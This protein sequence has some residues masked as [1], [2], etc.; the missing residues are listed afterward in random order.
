M[1]DFAC[2]QN[3]MSD[4]STELS[5][6]LIIV[7]APSG[8]GKTSLVARLLRDDPGIAL[9]VSWTTRPPRPGEQDGVHYHYTD[10]EHFRSLID[11]DALLEWAEVHGN[12]Y[13]TARDRVL[14]ELARGRD[15]LLEIDW[16]GA[17][18]V[19]QRL[20]F[21]QGIFILPPSRDTLLERLTRR[22]QDS[23]EVIARRLANARGEIEHHA[24]FDFLLVNDSFEATL[25]QLKHVV[26]AIRLQS[27][28][29][30][31]RHAAL[32]AQLLNP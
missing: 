3:R 1:A 20:P 12:Y 21:A 25:A 31:Q 18:Q 26:E 6:S 9:S 4:H 27:R 8:A 17:R 2:V 23:A 14:A 19:K 29:Q 28:P 10:V 15:V 5:G 22:G 30:R 11:A 7:A 24:E 13:G 16:Q 32:I